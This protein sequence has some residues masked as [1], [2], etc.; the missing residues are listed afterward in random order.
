MSYHSSLSRY[1][2][3]VVSPIGD[4]WDWFGGEAAMQAEFDKA[5]PPSSAYKTMLSTVADLEATWHP[6]GVYTWEQMAEVVAAAVQLAGQASSA[7]IT[8]F[9]SSSTPSAKDVVRKAADRYNLVAKQALDYVEAWKGA[10]AAG[11]PVEAP[12]FKKWVIDDLRAAAELMRT[13]EIQVCGAPW[14]LGTV[15]AIAGGF[16]SVANVAKRAVGVA[17]K[18]GE[19]ALKAVERTGSVVAFLLKWSPFIALGVGGFLVY[20]HVKKK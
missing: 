5:C 12:G 1:R 16:I 18:V 10:K 2:A 4:I 11:K 7:A 9:S 13:I 19:A 3:P 15:T 6:T 20:R 8:F 14:W 17:L